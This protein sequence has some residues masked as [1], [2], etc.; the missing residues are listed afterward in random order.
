M[1]NPKDLIIQR[2]VSREIFMKFI[3]QESLNGSDYKD[4]IKKLEDFLGYIK[5]DAID[6]YKYHGGSSLE[7]EESYRDFIFDFAY[8]M[9]ATRAYEIH[10]EDIDD[11]IDRYARNWSVKTLPKSDLSI[12]RTA[13]TEIK[14]MYIVPAQV[15][16]DE[17]VNLAKKYCED[18]AYRYINGILGSVVSE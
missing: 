9:D 5:E 3:F 16:C 11:L 8:L 14:F 10:R 7:D 18:G 6:L 15:S 13:I 4:L 17:A 12:L 2:R 1:S